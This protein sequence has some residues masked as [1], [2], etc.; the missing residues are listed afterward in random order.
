V[1]EEEKLGSNVLR[2]WDVEKP[3]WERDWDRIGSLKT[4]LNFFRSGCHPIRLGRRTKSNRAHLIAGCWDALDHFGFK[5]M[6]STN[7][8]LSS[9]LGGCQASID[10]RRR[11]Q[12][13]DGNIV[14][15]A[16]HKL[17]M[18]AKT[19]SKSVEF[20]A[21]LLSQLA[22]FCIVLLNHFRKASGS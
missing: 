1:A 9:L 2:S 11:G 14:V 10:Q 18:S 19:R 6:P 15:S 17:T 5:L 20:D 4:Q 22:V 3:T 8:P 12:D 7:S 13:H 21:D 16:I